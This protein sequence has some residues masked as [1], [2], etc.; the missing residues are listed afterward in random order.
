[1]L[2]RALK[3]A[4]RDSCLQEL[5]APL[6][7]TEG[8]GG[9]VPRMAARGSASLGHQQDRVLRGE[10]GR[11]TSRLQAVGGEG[12]PWGGGRFLTPAPP[13]FKAPC[14]SKCGASSPC[15]WGAPTLPPPSNFSPTIH[16]PPSRPNLSA[17]SDSARARK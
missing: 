17:K 12:T 3:Y 2:L 1:M 9:A 13:H 7:D 4:A 15:I 14:P 16:P 10:T 5:T 6:E 11:P 8:S